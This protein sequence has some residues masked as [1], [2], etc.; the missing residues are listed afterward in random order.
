MEIT[1]RNGQRYNL[2]N[3]AL[4]EIFE[5]IR[6]EDIKSLITHIM[7]THWAAIEHV[8]YVQTFKNLKIRYD[9]QMDRTGARDGRSVTGVAPSSGSNIEN[10]FLNMPSILRNNRF[11]RDARALEE[12]EE[13]WFD[14]EEPDLDAPDSNVVRPVGD[15]DD[16]S[17]PNS[18]QSPP[19]SSDPSDQMQENA[20]DGM[21]QDS[22]SSSSR[23]DTI[24]EAASSSTSIEQQELQATFLAAA[25]AVAAGMSSAD[26]ATSSSD[27]D[28]K[29]YAATND[30]NDSA[31]GPAD[32][33]DFAKIV[34]RNFKL[35]DPDESSSD[36]ITTESRFKVTS[37][38]MDLPGE[39][40]DSAG[41]C[42][43][44][45][46]SAHGSQTAGVLRGV[47]GENGDFEDDSN[48]SSSDSTSSSSSA[49][50]GETACDVSSASTDVTS[51]SKPLETKTEDTLN[52]L[53]S[54]TS[55][56]VTSKGNGE[57]PQ[58]FVDQ[59]GL[60]YT[61]SS[62]LSSSG[63]SNTM[64]VRNGF[65]VSEGSLVDSASTTLSGSSKEAMK[66]SERVT[67]SS[68]SSTSFEQVRR[69]LP[70]VDTIDPSASATSTMGSLPAVSDI[71]GPSATPPGPFSQLAAGC[72]NAATVVTSSPL[73]AAAIA[74]AMAAA[75]AATSNSPISSS[76]NHGVIDIN[77]E[78]MDANSEGEV[79]ESSSKGCL[80]TA[81]SSN[82]LLD[83]SKSTNTTAS[84]LAD[85]SV[86]AAQLTFM[87][88][89][90]NCQSSS[91]SGT[92]SHVSSSTYFGQ[93]LSNLNALSS[94]TPTSAQGLNLPTSSHSQT[95]NNLSSTTPLLSSSQ[96]QSSVSSS[97]TIGH[98]LTC[99]PDD[100]NSRFSMPVHRV[101]R[102]N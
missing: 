31:E 71:I 27:D 32:S 41:V 16:T 61:Q 70:A 62:S 10:M 26:D 2:L 43:S 23:E 40:G 6:V 51:L 4:L 81:T 37:A 83:L 8:D 46:N 13:M 101:R 84:F 47:V 58:D 86:V 9:Q 102:E 96:L 78:A 90:D 14:Q 5:F 21:C 89:T 85:S 28:E 19:H 95:P 15:V 53:S 79:Q 11:R 67:A 17:P 74:D 20:L 57:S 42:S 30:D 77:R 65:G 45:S 59:L 87:N 99:A 38:G 68:T 33:I 94:N 22:I 98:S 55:S 100:E 92:S 69:R 48:S 36:A 73:M 25:A 50:V 3:S 64:P 44:T 56:T 63:S 88:S 80:S 76:Q 18:L 54:T 66:D 24:A 12:E 91:S 1:N 52:G 82:Q 29:G 49:L 7:D 75:A 72:S 93:E 97:S 60:D 35:V 39:R 34:H